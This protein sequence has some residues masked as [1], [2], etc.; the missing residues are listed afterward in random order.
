MDL[1][2]DVGFG[3]GWIVGIRDDG[4]LRDGGGCWG[5]HPCWRVQTL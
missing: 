2:T 1:V 5:F 3:C 4:L